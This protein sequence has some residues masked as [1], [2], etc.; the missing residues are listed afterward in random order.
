[1]HREKVGHLSLLGLKY[2]IRSLIEDENVVL[3]P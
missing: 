2:T 3:F 1:M